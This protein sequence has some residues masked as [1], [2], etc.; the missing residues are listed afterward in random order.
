MRR[1]PRIRVP[2][3]RLTYANAMATLAVFMGLG[4]GAYAAVHVVSSDG[5][6]H[7]CADKKTGHLRLVGA[8]SKCKK[9]KHGE[10]PVDWNQKG[11]KGPEGP[12]GEVTP[13]PPPDEGWHAVAINPSMA[14]GPN[15]DPCGGAAPATGVFCGMSG[16]CTHSA[17]VDCAWENYGNG[18]EDAGFYR[19]SRGVVRLKGEVLGLRSPQG[20][21][22]SDTI[23]ILPPGYRPAARASFATDAGSAYGRVDVAPDGRLHLVPDAGGVVSLA[24]IEFRAAG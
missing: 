6:I 16:Q 23:F 10:V 13:P 17:A 1:S 20:A 5:V 4:G 2:R 19:D 11:A 15:V 22:P 24:T 14:G 8:D 7:G 21:P 12:R 3:P 18:Y 9:G